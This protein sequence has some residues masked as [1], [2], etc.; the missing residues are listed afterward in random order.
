MKMQTDNKV[1]HNPTVKFLGFMKRHNEFLIIYT[2]NYP[3]IDFDF[4]L[5]Y[6]REIL[7]EFSSTLRNVSH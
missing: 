2:T 7:N 5:S 6:M 3:H 4:F 1:M